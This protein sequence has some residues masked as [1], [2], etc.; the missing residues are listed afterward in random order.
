MRPEGLIRILFI[1]LLLTT[2][3]LAG[4][5]FTIDTEL[6]AKLNDS[7]ENGDV[8]SQFALGACYEL[9]KGTSRNV[10]E[11]A[12]WYRKAADQGYMAAEFCVGNCYFNGN[13]VPQDRVE[14]LKWYR[15]AADKGF[16]YAQYNLGTFYAKGDGVVQDLSKAVEWFLKAGNQGEAG[17]QY[18]LGVIYYKGDGVTKDFVEAY[19]WFNLASAQ[20]NADARKWRQ[21]IE[22]RMTA[23]QIAEAQKMAR[24]FRPSKSS[25]TA[26]RG[27]GADF[28]GPSSGTGFFIAEDGFMISNAHVI[29]GS[30]A[31]RLV[32]SAGLISAKVVK[33]DAA[34]ASRCSRRRA[35]LRRCRWWQAVECGWGAR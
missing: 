16:A 10:T 18:N 30:T 4:Q 7:A 22:S 34:N 5:E 11:A 23:N 19:K 6:F 35:G 31:I 3:P 17:A 15:R 29:E 28:K 13:G 8:V 27:G 14:A 9:G 2:S 1:V 20:G 33:V 26:S 32:T 24:E 21:I 25:S 12:K